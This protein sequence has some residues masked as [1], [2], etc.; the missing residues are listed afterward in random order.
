VSVRLKLRIWRGP[1]LGLVPSL[2]PSLMLGLALLQPASAGAAE[3]SFGV[4]SP[5]TTAAQEEAGLRTAIRHSDADNLGFV[6]VNGIKTAAE[7]CSDQLYL[8]RK[9][10]LDSAKNG[11][12]VSLASG[13]WLGCKNHAGRSLAPERL[14]RLRELFFTEDF[15]LGASR[16]PL[17]RQSTAPKFRS[18]AENA[19]WEFGDLLFATI[20][21]PANNNHYLSEAGRNSEFEDRQIANRHW[22]QRL[23]DHAT[24]KKLNAIVLFCDGNPLWP[25]PPRAVDLRGKYD[26][27]ADIRQRLIAASKKFPGKVLV[28]H[29]PANAERAPA[30]IVWHGNLGALAVHPGWLKITA[31]DDDPKLFSIAAEAAVPAAN[32]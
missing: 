20:N 3:I 17:I 28:V 6:V 15:S 1:L 29:G 12:V 14:S 19:R 5:A 22:L 10:L 8:E 26:G 25:P 27:F 9:I 11:L 21:L 4:I 13:D 30:E 16:I 23:F 2:V 7:P 24:Y 31:R 32:F 18:Y